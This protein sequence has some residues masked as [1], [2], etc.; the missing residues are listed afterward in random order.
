MTTLNYDKIFARLDKI[1]GLPLVRKGYRW[2]GACYLNGNKHGRWDKVVARQGKDGGIILIEQGYG[3]IA[4]WKWMKEFGGCATDKEV[5][6]ILAGT[7][8]LEM[9]VP[10]PPPE[11]PAKYV[12]KLDLTYPIENDMLFK[13]LLR[14]F[15]FDLVYNTYKQW[16]ITSKMTRIGKLGTSFWFVNKHGKVCHDKMII[17]KENGRRDHSY[18]GGRDYRTADGYKHRCYFGEHLFGYEEDKKVY[19]VESEKTAILFWLLYRKPV[20][21]CGGLNNLMEIKDNYVL[22]PDIDGY[23]LWSKKG[24][25]EKWWESYDF[26]CGD[27]ADIGDFIVKILEDR[28]KCVSLDT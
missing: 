17:Y 7:S 3:A 16:N 22:L 12:R 19:I 20:M 25:A 10:P 4:L 14:H 15:D 18:G 9:D 1:T 27:K 6:N 28:K 11:K 26:W 23:E 24:Y 21:A 8:I 5:Y 13:W 2:Y